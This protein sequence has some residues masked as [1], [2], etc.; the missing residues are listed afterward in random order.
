MADVLIVC[1]RED[2]PLAKAF[3]DMFERAG[4]HVGG[5]PGAPDDMRNCGAALV[6]WS[7]ASIR[8][9]A[10]LDAAQRAVNAGK[11]VVACLI[12]P[13]PAA[14]INHAPAFDLSHWAGDPDDPTLDPL[15]FAVDRMVAAVR[16]SAGAAA[17]VAATAAAA[18]ARS[19][20]ASYF[21]APQAPAPQASPPYA[22]ARST[23]TARPA[24]APGYDIPRAPAAAARRP[25]PAPGQRDPDNV[26]A[27][28][29]N[30][31]A[32]RH[33]RNPEDFLRHLADFGSEGAFA[34]LAQMR[35]AEL[36][37]E[38]RRRRPGAASPR[39]E[40]PARGGSVR[41]DPPRP[42]SPRA[43]PRME[44]PRGRGGAS[45]PPPAAFEP[46]RSEPPQQRLR[47]APSRGEAPPA[48]RDDG[49]ALA[50]RPDVGGPPR[51]S[52]RTIRMMAIIVVLGGAALGAG[53]FAG[54]RFGALNFLTGGGAEQSADASAWEDA[55][56]GETADASA[57]LD[58]GGGGANLSGPA[59]PDLRRSNAARIPQR[60]PAQ[61]GPTIE[62][63]PAA[64][65]I[66]PLRTAPPAERE[67][68]PAP[69]ALT[70]APA[71]LQ[72]TPAPQPQIQTAAVEPPAPAQVG[73]PRTP[74]VVWAARPGAQRI[75]ELFPSRALRS[76]QG[77]RVELD[78]L[79]DAAGVPRCAVANE[80]P[81]GFG[82]G[83]AALRAS[84]QFRAQANLDDGTRSAGAQT[85]LTI[86]FRQPSPGQ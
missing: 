49:R 26:A 12:A 81:S 77:G 82:F 17:P 61:G 4:L 20:P 85:R 76:N 22:R 60:P 39:G 11:A 31:A 14:S 54:D 63:E 34:E 44:A 80:T 66:N 1:V 52:S 42:A 78:C 50:R 86:V 70:P 33:S 13:P 30:W 23:P 47:G 56:P 7:Q 59:E 18:P 57:S 64:R 43:E 8:S 35:L 58:F 25:G 65:E 21:N 55:P 10:F 38:N 79:L 40:A 51:Q 6:V 16:A 32:I 83:A 3:A 67:A 71:P 45:R 5:A 73:P 75:N 28:A 84:G 36:E 29:Q 9:R 48:W 62:R 15:F 41:L 2:E 68:A 53:L 74:Q 24:A 37:A 27:E 69:V 72:L 19:E 46:I